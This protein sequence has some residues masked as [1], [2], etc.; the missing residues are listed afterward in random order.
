MAARAAVGGARGASICR[1]RWRWREAPGRWRWREGREGLGRSG[2]ESTGGAGGP[3][4]GA[5]ARVDGRG[6]G[7]AREEE[8]GEKKEEKERRKTGR[9]DL[10]LGFLYADG[11]AIGIAPPLYADGK[12]VGIAFFVIFF[13][14]KNYINEGF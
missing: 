4:G 2:G 8:G 3:A 6:C 13:A 1:W 7:G 10:D 5:A 14:R 9:P 11:R 12:A